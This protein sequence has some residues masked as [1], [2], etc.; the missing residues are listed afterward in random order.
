MKDWQIDRYF[1]QT[2]CLCG[3]TNTWHLQ[4]FTSKTKE[5]VHAAYDRVY[6]KLR[7]QLASE[8]QAARNK[9]FDIGDLK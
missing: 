2:P 5:Q 9:C 7:K 6:A 1:G 8:R 3:A 4:C